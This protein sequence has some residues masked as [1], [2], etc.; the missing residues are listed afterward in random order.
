MKKKLLTTLLVIL[1]I[2]CFAQIKFE[3]GYY[4]SDSNQKTECLIKN[5]DWKSNPT[6]FEYKLAEGDEIKTETIKTVKEFGVYDLAKFVRET[7][8]IDRS[9]VN[10]QELSRERNPIFKEET[11]FLRV[12]VEGDY[13]LY[14]YADANLKR[15]FYNNK[16]TKIQQLV[17]KQYMALHNYDNKPALNMATKNNYYQQQLFN[18]LKCP[19]ITLNKVEKVQYRRDDLLKFFTEYNQC[20]NSEPTYVQQK[21]KRNKVDLTI[22]PRINSSSLSIDNK[23]HN[24]YDDQYDTQV[25]FGFGLEGEFYLPYNKNKWSIIV[26]PTYQTYTAEK[27]TGSRMN[28]IAKVDYTSIELPVGLRH[29]FYISPKSKIFVNGTYSYIFRLDSNITFTS[30]NG[31]TV[32]YLEVEP[33][34]NFAFG[35]GYKYNDKLS[36]EVRYNTRH[37]LDN[38]FEWLTN[39]KSVSLIVGYTIF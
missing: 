28:Y 19:T 7:V 4:I 2:N 10:I 9:S 36:V 37:I 25:N 30:V 34:K 5:I 6:Q 23:A 8:D 26:E 33:N 32:E 13:N 21:P 39:F 17:Y 3:N 35:A 11:L 12:L 16:D 18:D 31:A 20:N 24:R 1:T 27:I 29:Y 38:Y 15:F 14:E 22:R